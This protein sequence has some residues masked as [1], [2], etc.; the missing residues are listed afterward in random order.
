MMSS[1]KG[2]PIAMAIAIFLCAG[3]AHSAPLEVKQNADPRI[4]YTITAHLNGAPGPF[5]RAEV[6]VSY[7]VDTPDCV[8]LTPVA[9]ATVVPQRHIRVAME[10]RGDAF[11]GTVLFDLFK[12]EDY[13]GRGVCH[14]S[15]VGVTTDFHHG[16]VTFSPAIYKAD[17]LSGRKIVKYFSKRSYE[18]SST[19]RIDI[20]ATDPDA[21]DDPN[22][23]FAIDIHATEE[24]R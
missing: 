7:R 4:R 18:R 5:D 17:M 21:Y 19:A 2:A 14:W 20:G 3:S 13:F 9:G 10:P 8:P 24:R 23:I 11:V 15:V 12:D 6:G 22:A 1:A 16:S